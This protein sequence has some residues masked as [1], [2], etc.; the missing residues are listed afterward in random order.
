MVSA[1]H[2]WWRG[3]EFAILVSMLE[4]KDSQPPGTVLWGPWVK[5]HVIRRIIVL[6]DGMAGLQTLSE[7]GTTWAPGSME[8]WL[9]TF[10]PSSARE[11]SPEEAA[12]LPT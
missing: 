2:F 6:P 3:N 12:E 8:N 7:D 4:P 5:E 10:P 11:L 9:E 1:N